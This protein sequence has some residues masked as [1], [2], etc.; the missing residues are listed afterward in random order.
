MQYEIGQAGLALFLATACVVL[1]QNAHVAI[2]W[3]TSYVLD[4]AMRFA[5]GQVPY[6]DFPF[7]HPP[8]TFLV[9]AAI[10]RFTGRVY[11]HHVLYVSVV[12]GLA[13]LLSWRIALA[14]LRGRI[15]GA[16]TV[17]LLLA[18]PLTVLGI[19]CII[20]IPEYDGE[21]AFWILVAL[22]LLQKIDFT[23]DAKTPRD[24]NG[25]CHPERS[26][27]AGTAKRRESK[28]LRL[29]FAEQRRP[30][31]LARGFVAGVALCLPLFTKQ[32]MGLP[33]LIAAVA[34][35]LLVLA[36]TSIRRGKAPIEA[37][38][39]PTLLSVLAGAFVTL[40]AA[41]LALHWT[42]GLRNYIYWTITFAGQRRLPPLDLMLSVFRDPALLWTL[43]CV[44]AGL[45]LLRLPHPS[46]RLDRANGG[47]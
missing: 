19:Y 21:C 43:P 7:V 47:S 29:L 8:L 39:V 16:W 24:Q 11:F 12:G 25:P 31:Q 26:E 44:A 17:A 35:V 27:Q 28:D 22:W 41:A 40:F 20:P 37:P 30:L 23:S 6:R 14:S 18:A 15:A 2:L 42:A 34:A 10:I 33:F 3:D 36:I 38:V 46:R 45:A 9:Q 4:S 5:L 1:W 32:N 13:T